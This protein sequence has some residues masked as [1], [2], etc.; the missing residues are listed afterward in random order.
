MIGF[1][2]NQTLTRVRRAVDGIGKGT[3]IEEADFRCRAELT[4]I[5]VAGPKGERFVDRYRIFAFHD[6][7]IQKGDHVKV[8]GIDEEWTVNRVFEVRGFGPSHLEIEV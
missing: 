5:R 3:T 8:D 2:L 1:A 6:A 7:D 4:R